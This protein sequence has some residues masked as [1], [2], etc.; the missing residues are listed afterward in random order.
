MQVV[1]RDLTLQDVSFDKIYERIKK[2]AL[3]L[4]L[5][6]VNCVD[7][8]K[9][10]IQGL[11]DR[12][13][14]EELDFYAANKC[15]DKIQNDPQYDKL[16]A[17]ILIS[18]LHKMTSEDFLKVTECLYNN[19]DI[20]GENHPLVSEEYYKFV[21]T[22]KDELNKLIDY[23]RDY[24]FDFFGFKTLEQQGYLYRIKNIK[25]QDKF[26]INNKEFNIIKKFGRIVE[27][28]QHMLLR[29]AICVSKFDMVD[30]KNNYYLFSNLH[31]THASPTLFN[32]GSP[33]PQ[34][35]SCFLLH[36][37]DS[38]KGIFNETISETADISK[39]SGGIGIHMQNIRPKGSYIRGTNGTSDGIIPLCKV[40]NEIARYVNQGG[41][42]KGAI[43]LYLEPWHGDIY[44][45]C[46]LRKSVG[47]EELRARDIFTG[48]WIPDL[49]MKRVKKGELW[50]LMSPDE[51][52]G[53]TSTFGEEFEKLYTKYETE[54]KFI[55][56]VKAQDLWRHILTCQ[57]E[58]GVPYMLF[59][60]TANKLSNQK[61]I[62]VLTGSN[63]CTEILEVVSEDE[64]AVCNLASICLPTCIK[65][66]SNNNYYFDYKQL[67]DCT[68]QVT[69]NL[70]N[71]IDI[72]YYPSKKAFN[73]NSR[74]RPIAIGTQGYADVLC[75]LQLPFV[76]EE[77]TKL[78]RKIHET[79]YYAAL[80]ESMELAKKYGP[81][82]TFKGSPFSEGKLQFDLWNIDES[83]LSNELN[84]NEL[85]ENIK[86]YGTRNSLITS[87]MPT[88]STAQIMGNNEAIEPFSYNLYK[89]KTLA[90]EFIII[91]KY[92][93]EDLIKLDLWNEETKNILIYDNGSI[94]YAPNIP[95][96]I[97]EI[98]KTAYEIGPQG[99]I[100]Q[101]VARGPFIDQSQSLN[102]F[103]KKP[104]HKT[105]SQSHFYS[106]KKQ[107]KTGM[108]YLR[109]QPLVNPIKFGME[110][111]IISDIETARRAY[112][113]EHGTDY[114]I[115]TS[116]NS[117]SDFKINEVVCSSCT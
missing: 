69:R 12:I 92:L 28:P 1:K 57:L 16:A 7:I 86:I 60:D 102:L 107:L 43:A 61:N 42:R 38:I 14:T 66:D 52:K 95:D 108:Y 115:Y 99:I 65:K 104:D 83:L 101:A 45:F 8:A 73:S 15:A 24:L 59:K 46:E 62:G 90:G 98:Y 31:V 113:K 82:S 112:N 53:L 3:Q 56:Q 111:S 48:L 26:N 114:P 37:G 34:M 39:N 18:N 47:A 50:S 78:N 54:G 11:Y 93:V 109:S 77:A 100:N 105:L 72:N 30:I 55:R 91:N 49:F 17:G 19:I 74:H 9:E 88:A 106:W 79:I 76:T 33:R 21:K 64:T 22:N 13:T 87:I 89:R 81:Y 4:N 84:W 2:I 23:S 80:T 96:Y 27:R 116:Y 63:L 85:R 103:F 32:S 58:T 29:V 70:N 41:R 117:S 35:S 44:E 40:L 94:Q 36:M 75:L 97:K 110:Q 67:Y 6:R 5:T 68:R 10:T 71:V 20:L 25:C 51:C